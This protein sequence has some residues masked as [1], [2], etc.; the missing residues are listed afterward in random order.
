LAERTVFLQFIAF[1]D[2]DFACI[3][4]NI[5]NPDVGGFFSTLYSPFAAILQICW[6][7]ILFCFADPNKIR[8][9]SNEH[10]VSRVDSFA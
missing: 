6:H 5:K 1:D 10:C 3:A 8:Q 9:V 4:L 7:T 2:V